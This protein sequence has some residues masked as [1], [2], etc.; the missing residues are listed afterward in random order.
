MN[1]T[2]SLCAHPKGHQYQQNGYTVSVCDICGRVWTSILPQSW[3]SA[4]ER[5]PPA[6]KESG[7]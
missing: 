4:Y 5:Q 2:V 7:E 1:N 3:P 6:Q